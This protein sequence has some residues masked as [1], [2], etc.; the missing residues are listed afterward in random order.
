MNA[1]L[2]KRPVKLLAFS[3]ALALCLSFYL[4]G[5][6]LTDN[7]Y[8][9][10]N[11]R[12]CEDNTM[13]RLSLEA[14]KAWH[15]TF[16]F[17]LLS[18]RILAWGLNV[19]SVL[20]PYC[21]LFGKEEREKNI[22]YLCAAL[23][24]MGPGIAKCCTPDCFTSLMLSVLIVAFIKFTQGKCEKFAWLLLCVS[25]ALLTALRFPNIVV[26][27]FVAVFMVLMKD[28][29]RKW[30]YAILY[31]VLSMAMYWLVMTWLLGNTN[32]ISL[33]GESF[34]REAE[35]SNGRHSAIG[36]VLRYCKSILLALIALFCITIA[37]LT[38]TKFFHQRKKSGFIVAGVVGVLLSYG[39]LGRI[40]EKFHSWPVC[41]APLVSLPLLYVA[42]HAFKNK[43]YMNVWLCLFLC[44]VIF[45]P[46]AGSDTGFQ[47]SLM[48]ACGMAPIAI[49]KYTKIHKKT[50][51]INIAL[52]IMLVT[53][54]FMYSD[55]ICNNNAMSSDKKLWGI[56]LTKWQLESSQAI[57]EGLEPY[58]RK[59]HTVFYGLE[60][61]YWYFYTDTK[62][63]YNP[64]FWM[65]KDDDEALNSAI[66]S[67][68]EDPDNVFI[69]FTKS[70]KEYF[71]KKGIKHVSGTDM[72]DIYKY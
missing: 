63:L 13:C 58:Y 50:A 20:I 33:L 38:R 45:I 9:I 48:S 60:A 15:Y 69:D 67:L 28:V 17:T 12:F 42:Y 40:G 70:A 68:E 61:H 11:S 43:D 51:Y 16:G 2:E 8:W 62:P 4:W 39:I 34:A 19:L 21:S 23:I 14:M 55:N 26:V 7:Y 71:L 27:P 22:Y 10:Y 6:T 72:Y 46:S 54:V 1:L 24:V 57:K 30:Q 31:V 3:L 49:V 53:S 65:L 59:N 44:L 56:M 52:S 25:T 64:G 35:N 36:L 66:A 47:K 18:N 29:N 5:V 32:C 41:I 37:C